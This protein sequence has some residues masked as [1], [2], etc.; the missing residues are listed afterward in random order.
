M[1]EKKNK[2]VE[3]FKL[4][5][6]ERLTNMTIGEMIKKKDGEKENHVEEKAKMEMKKMKEELKGWE[7]KIKE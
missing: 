6:D 2:I 3:R 7:V 1:L 4:D 5:V